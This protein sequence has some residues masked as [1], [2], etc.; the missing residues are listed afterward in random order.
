MCWWERGFIFYFFLFCFFLFLNA[1]HQVQSAIQTAFHHHHQPVAREKRRRKTYSSTGSLHGRLY[2]QTHTAESQ[3][4]DLPS[5]SY[6]W[7][8]GQGWWMWCRFF[9]IDGQL[10]INTHT[11]T[12]AKGKECDYYATAKRKEMKT[13]YRII[14]VTRCN[15][16]DERHPRSRNS[17]FSPR[18]CYYNT[19]PLLRGQ[20][21]RS[22]RKFET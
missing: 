17:S 21:S 8:D 12:R 7:N 9:G 13:R 15:G 22:I 20:V 3:R 18:R 10:G 1:A 5:S 4:A 19:R 2:I 16:R 14:C 11:H 6:R